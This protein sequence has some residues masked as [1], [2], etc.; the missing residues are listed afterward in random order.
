[1]TKPHRLWR[2]PT[3]CTRARELRAGGM[4][5]D[6][7]A[8]VMTEEFGISITTAAFAN[9]IH[10]HAY[11]LI[12]QR[13]AKQEPISPVY[14][15]LPTPGPRANKL[16]TVFTR[17]RREIP[18]DTRQRNVNAL[19]A[20]AKRLT[21]ERPQVAAD[22]RHQAALWAGSDT[23]FAAFDVEAAHPLISAHDA[24]PMLWGA[25]RKETVVPSSSALGAVGGWM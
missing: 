18:E 7:A 17:R 14:C 22:L 21:V 1:M 24:Q 4:S 2:D 3:A 11:D 13:P 9:W 5:H 10:L 15:P 20:V 19:L 23:N 12:S 8:A 25:L 6:E 16:R